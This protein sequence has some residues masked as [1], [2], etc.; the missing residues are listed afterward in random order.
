MKV[1]S[2]PEDNEENVVVAHEERLSFWDFSKEM[3]RSMPKSFLMHPEKR[4][5]PSYGQP[6]DLVRISTLMAGD[7]TM[8]LPF[9]DT[10]TRK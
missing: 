10:I 9:M 3:V 1:I 2:V 6:C 4:F 8:R 5:S 7:H